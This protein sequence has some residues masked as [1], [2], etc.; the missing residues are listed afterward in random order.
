MPHY[1]CSSACGLICCDGCDKYE[2][3]YSGGL[4]KYHFCKMF[5]YKPPQELILKKL[6]QWS[7]LQN[8]SSKKAKEDFFFN[9]T[10]GDQ[11]R[12]SFVARQPQPL[13]PIDFFYIFYP[14]KLSKITD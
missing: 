4:S 1:E 14:S 10:C 2:P 12:D 13:I 3:S 11:S 5:P 7:N 6:L 9:K 8:G